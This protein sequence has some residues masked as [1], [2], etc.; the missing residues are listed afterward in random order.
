M[1]I[2][3]LQ[4]LKILGQRSTLQTCTTQIVNIKQIG[5]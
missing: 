3:Q 1:G 4:E 2:H 5:K